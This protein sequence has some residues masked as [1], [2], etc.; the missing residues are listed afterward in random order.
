MEL[1]PKK[2]PPPYI[3]DSN[4]D[5]TAT[6]DAPKTTE[7]SLAPNEVCRIT[8][9]KKKRGVK[10]NCVIKIIREDTVIRFD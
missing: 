8:L 10:K 5:I 4:Q 7:V 2:T 6:I 3:G 9:T 1:M